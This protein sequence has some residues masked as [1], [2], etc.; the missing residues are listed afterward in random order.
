MGV[1]IHALTRRATTKTLTHRAIKV[2][3]S[4]PSRGGRRADHRGRHKGSQFQSTPSRGGRPKVLLQQAYD[5]VFQS[6]PS[7]GG[8]LETHKVPSCIVSF[9]PRPHAEGDKAERDRL[10]KVLVSIHALTRRATFQILA[11]YATTAFQS[12]PSRGGRLTFQ[13][14]HPLLTLFQSTPS[15]GGRPQRAV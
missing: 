7:R 10:K 6:T 9:N 8:R 14:A 15:R 4:T 11:L 3:Q 1:S 5:K 12:T 2:F 13:A